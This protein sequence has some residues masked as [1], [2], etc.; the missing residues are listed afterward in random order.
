MVRHFA[1]I[2]TAAALMLLLTLGSFATDSL[3]AISEEDKTISSVAAAAIY[4]IENDTVVFSYNADKVLPTAS[5]TKMMTAVCAYELLS[6][7]LDET[8]TVEGRMIYSKN[9]GYVSGRYVGYYIGEVVRIRDLFCGLLMRGANDSAYMLCYAAMNGADDSVEQFVAY[10]NEKAKALGM[11][12][13]YYVNQTGL[14]AEGMVTTAADSL[15]IATEFYKIDFL[16][17]ISNAVSYTI[18]ASNKQGQLVIYNENGLKYN[19]NTSYRYH[20]SRVIGINSGMT[21]SSGNYAA[22]AVC[23]EE[24]S[25]IIV[26][27]GGKELDGRNSAYLLTSELATKA[28]KEYGYVEVIKTSKIVTEIPVNLSTE[29]DYVTLVPAQS[30]TL[31]LPYSLDISSDLTYSFRLDVESLS[32]P[33]TEGQKVG[34][35][36][37]SRDEVLLGSVDLIT[38]NSV[39]RSEFLV[40]LDK[41]ES[42]TTSTF[43]IVTVIAAVVL[44][45]AYFI[46]SAVLRNRRRNRHYRRR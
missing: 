9:G 8:V 28:L 13:T 14:D 33:V 17:G 46:I 31:Y 12:D 5:F 22:S 4:N 45:V 37:V 23:G 26:V 40:V 7:R 1:N 34:S 29:A 2:I 25:Y 41:I 11:K 35:Y 36:T 24:L 43:F 3:D 10:M 21:P 42:F 39:S 27:L 16:T 6:D 15:K 44:T 30:L 38:K 20:D 18:P 32:A 19:S